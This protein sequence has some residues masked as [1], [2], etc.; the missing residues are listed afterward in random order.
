M[1]EILRRRLNAFRL[2]AANDRV[3]VVA[4]VEQRARQGGVALSRGRRGLCC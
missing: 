1:P 3:G 2:M 4:G